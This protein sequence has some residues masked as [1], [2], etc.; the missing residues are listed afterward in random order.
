MEN[1]N[2]L[3]SQ[4]ID[5]ACSLSLPSEPP[6]V[7]NWFGSYT[8][9]PPLLSTS[10]CFG[11]SDLKIVEEFVIQESIKVK[12]KNRGEFKKTRSNEELGFVVKEPNSTVFTDKRKQQSPSKILDS[13]YTLSQVSEP[14]EI[15]NWFSSY[16]Y[17]SFVLDTNDDVKNSITQETDCE[18]EGSFVMGESQSEQEN[19][20]TFIETRSCHGMD[21]G[22]EIG[23]NGFVK[24]NDCFGD[25]KHHGNDK[26]SC[27]LDSH[28]IFT[29]PPDLKN[30]FS[31][32]VY[33]SPVLST[34]DEVEDS[35]DLERGPEIDELVAADSDVENEEGVV[36]KAHS[37]GLVKHNPSYEVVEQ[38]NDSI[39]KEIGR[40]GGKEA[41]SKKFEKSNGIIPSNGVE[42]LSF[43]DE[44]SICKP[45]QEL[46][47]YACSVS[48][49]IIRSS[50]TTRKKSPT[51][52]YNRTDFTEE[53]LEANTQ[54]KDVNLLSTTCKPEI[55]PVSGGSLRK[56]T[57]GSND[58]ENGFAATRKNGYIR[59]E[60]EGFLSRPRGILVG[61]PKNKGTVSCLAGEKNDVTKRKALMET[62][63]FQHSDA[64]EIAGK[65]RCP[66]KSKPNRGPPVKQ[67]RLERWFHR[68]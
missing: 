65:W 29:E 34:S 10:D 63:N 25:D 66:Q 32:Y 58:K 45:V 28:S 24:S 50:S 68:A 36:K 35:L 62:T 53:G 57:H 7:G 26:M 33:E 9:E 61:C 59:T 54:I 64:L 14:P 56:Q 40:T 6:D 38:E 42:Q 60:N 23:S 48:L 47:P 30:W 8:Y 67:L 41:L 39:I 3:G 22:K 44:G 11:D 27:S 1:S 4:I 12:E 5:S 37:N 31:N 15:G 43:N 51:K 46:S 17:E 18:K 19:M 16:V 49:N 52:F 55:S 21:V 13:S 2:H 20:A